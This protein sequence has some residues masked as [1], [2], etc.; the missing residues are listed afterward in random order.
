MNSGPVIRLHLY[1]ARD[2]N[3]AAIL[4]QGPGK[5]FRMI[6]WDRE[7]GTFEDGQWLK[8]KIY[9]ERCDLSPDGRHFIYFAL[10]G[11]WSGETEG[12]YTAIS[13]PPY[14]TALALFPEGDTWSGGGAFLD[15][16]HYVA[17]GGQDIVGRADG[18]ERLFRTTPDST[19]VTGLRRADGSCA[20]QDETDAARADLN[21]R[22]ADPA[23]SLY[24]TQGGILYRRRGPDLTP[25]R[26]FTD[27]AFER[28]RAPYDWRG[29]NAPP[30][31][32]APWH[33]LDGEGR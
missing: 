16:R 20:G 6:L 19:C 33:P 1:F 14:F 11:D 31:P 7:A 3:L 2:S 25:I 5:V 17:H 4:R 30:E 26:D 24:D 12:S 8:H 10:N 23:L 13:R 18:L 22:P 32:A 15:S 27:M 29:G 9:P 28:I 21:A